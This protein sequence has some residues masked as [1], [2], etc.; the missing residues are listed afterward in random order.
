MLRRAEGCLRK[1]CQLV[2]TSL[3]AEMLLPA[4]RRQDWDGE[5]VLL[6]KLVTLG[7]VS[8]AASNGS[9]GSR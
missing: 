4:A 1:R 6:K 9:M 2:G 7:F 3:P 5:E 8:S